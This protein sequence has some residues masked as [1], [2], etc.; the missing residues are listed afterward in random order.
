MSLGAQRRNVLQ[1]VLRQGLIM[2]AA[3]LALGLAGAFSLTRVM[4]TILYGIGANDSR[5][6][7]WS[8]LLLAVVALLASYVPAHRAT[9]IDPVKALHHD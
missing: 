4:A 5:T 3:G 2:T 1:L 7:G 8:A 6:F 9:L